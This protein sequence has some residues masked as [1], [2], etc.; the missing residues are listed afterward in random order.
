MK[1]LL[2]WS[3]ELALGIPEIDEEHKR[4]VHL[5]NRVY[6]AWLYRHIMVVDRRYAEYAR[7]RSGAPEER[8]RPGEEEAGDIGQEI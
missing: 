8:E 7:G 6:W 5:I 1:Q 4:L 2:E 3:D